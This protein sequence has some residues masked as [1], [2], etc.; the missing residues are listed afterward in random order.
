[1][2]FDRKLYLDIAFRVIAKIISIFEVYSQS[3]SS[4]LICFVH[5]S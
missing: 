1:M 2:L 5:Y 3:T 4:L